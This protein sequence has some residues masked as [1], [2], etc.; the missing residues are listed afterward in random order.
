[1]ASAEADREIV[2]IAERLAALRETLGESF[3]TDAEVRSLQASLKRSIDSYAAWS[4]DR[5][6]AHQRARRAAQYQGAFARLLWPR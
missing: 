4:P 2:E 1:M 3:W 6:P 5:L